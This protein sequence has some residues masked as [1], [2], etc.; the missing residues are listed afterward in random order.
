MKEITNY[1]Q[2][3]DIDKCAKC[4]YSEM[5][6]SLHV[7]HI[8][9][10][11][12]N[13]NSNNLLVLCANCHYGLHRNAWKLSD[14]G[15]E[16]PLFS[17]QSCT[18]LGKVAYRKELSRLKKENE[19]LSNQ[20]KFLRSIADEYIKDESGSLERKLSLGKE[21]IIRNLLYRNSYA[22]YYFVMFILS[23]VPDC[24]FMN[25]KSEFGNYTS[26]V[27][28]LLE[29]MYVNKIDPCNIESIKELNAIL[30][31]TIAVIQEHY[32]TPSEGEMQEAIERKAII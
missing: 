21:F 18:R 1:R 26:S 12:K 16:E 5:K 17:K 22:Y 7:H 24:Y 25:I 27:A 10:N 23:Q 15:I 28:N 29:K 9:R 2:L 14:I 3:I 8:D 4:G 11:H 13:N 31:D 20:V 6:S 32:S 30:N 19:L